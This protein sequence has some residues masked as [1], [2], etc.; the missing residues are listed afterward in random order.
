MSIE[1][2]SIDTNQAKAELK[3]C[4]KI[5][6]DYVKSLE[7]VYEMNRAT[8]TNAINKLKLLGTPAVV[9]QSEQ[10]VCD[11]FNENWIY[12]ESGVDMYCKNCEPK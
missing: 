12:D 5:V 3:K 11:C 8:L 4:P 9:G 2:K 7:S 6:Q 1:V 10:L